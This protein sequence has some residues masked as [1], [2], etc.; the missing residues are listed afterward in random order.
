V[1]TATS[2]GGGSGYAQLRRRFQRRG[3][4][5]PIEESILLGFAQGAG[6]DGVWR[7]SVV[8]VSGGDRGR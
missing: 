8:E 7:V 3:V 1:V 6:G 5:D 4:G 2:V